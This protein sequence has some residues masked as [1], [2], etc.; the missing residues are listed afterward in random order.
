MYQ[1]PEKLKN[2]EI[3]QPVTESYR[4]RLDANESF[5]DLPDSIREGSGQR[6]WLQIEFRPLSGSYS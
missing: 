1:I 6:R 2:L 4:V 3:Y 5:L